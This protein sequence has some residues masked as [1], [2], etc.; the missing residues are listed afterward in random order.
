MDSPAVYIPPGY[1]FEHCPT[2]QSPNGPYF[3]NDVVAALRET[4]G[5][6]SEAARLLGRS[7]NGLALYID[8]HQEISELLN[9]EREAF[10]DTAEV[11]IRE[12][13]DAGDPASVRFV[14]TT[15][16]RFRGWAMK[17]TNASP[18]IDDDPQNN[19]PI[20][21]LPDNGRK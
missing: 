18:G 5:I 15:L 2:R 9:D 8:K 11:K 21:Y 19:Q 4:R 20:I 7:R 12:L 1:D 17:I 14:L 10:I 13:V 6:I 16:G 3:H